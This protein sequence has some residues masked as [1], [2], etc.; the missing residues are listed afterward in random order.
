MISRAVSLALIVMLLGQGCGRSG[1]SIEEKR[2]DSTGPVIATASVTASRCDGE[3]DQRQN[4]KVTPRKAAVGERIDFHGGCFSEFFE[5]DDESS[6]GIGGF[7]GP[8]GRASIYNPK[9]CPFKA[10]GKGGY[11][12]TPSG[13]MRGYLIIPASGQCRFEDEKRSVV[14]GK[15]RL[16]VGC[17]SCGVGSVTVTRK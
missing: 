12:L 4:V 8:N 1:G 14:P 6:V 9:G 7:V 10:F 13:S 15:Y 11:R 2:A 3:G 5:P 17:Y 16:I